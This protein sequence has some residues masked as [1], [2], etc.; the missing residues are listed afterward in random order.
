MGIGEKFGQILD[1]IKKMAHNNL[2]HD[3]RAFKIITNSISICRPQEKLLI[4]K[5]KKRSIEEEYLRFL[6]NNILNSEESNI[7]KVVSLIRRFNWEKNEDMIFRVIFKYLLTNNEDK[8]NNCC[9]MLFLLKNYH[10]K[11]FF[12]LINI[13]LEEIRI[14]LERN[15]FND[16]QH[17]LILSIIVGNFYVNKIITSDLVFYIL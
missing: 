13:I 17:K 10:Q 2:V 7:K 3:D 12:N 9:R 11:F 6:M 14:G 8:I 16:N 15:D 5:V 4:K 1:T